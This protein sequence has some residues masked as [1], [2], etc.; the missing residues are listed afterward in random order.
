MTNARHEVK[1]SKPFSK[2]ILTMDVIYFHLLENFTLIVGKFRKHFDHKIK[3][4]N[5]QKKKP[6]VQCE[7]MRQIIEVRSVRDG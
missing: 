6:E 4:P 2:L 7:N 1:P 5:L 3:L